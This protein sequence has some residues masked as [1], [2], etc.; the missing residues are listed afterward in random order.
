[1]RNT[2]V[3]VVL[4]AVLVLSA[5]AGI[6]L[7]LAK[8]SVEDTGN[9]DLQTEG[10]VLQTAGNE[11]GSN[12]SSVS[13]GL[14][15]EPSGEIVIRVYRNGTPLPGATVEITGIEEETQ[16]DGIYVT[17]ENGEITFEED[18]TE[19]LP[20]VVRIRIE[21]TARNVKASYPFIFVR[22]DN[23]VES[24]TIGKQVSSTLQ[25][26]VGQTRGAVE[27]RM[28]LSKVNAAQ[29][30]YARIELMRE[31]SLEIVRELGGQNDVLQNL[32]IRLT[33]S[34]ITITEF[35]VRQIEMQSREETLKTELVYIL[36][37]LRMYDDERLSEHGIDPIEVDVL[38]NNLR[39]NRRVEYDVDVFERE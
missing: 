8:T 5:F 7:G 16:I 14:T 2:A 22:R 21:I 37:R 6:G 11:S 26:S 10:T 3:S 12:S 30:D 19:D 33:T 36:E 38:Y 31:R 35:Y 25:D 17:N 24:G 32:Q 23:F 29:S 28:F 1:M 20:L 27:A 15:Q 9:S 13:V 4:A 18:T 39:N 34:E